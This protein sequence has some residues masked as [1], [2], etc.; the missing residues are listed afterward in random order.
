MAIKGDHS[1]TAGVELGSKWAFNLL[2]EDSML[3]GALLTEGTAFDEL[4]GWLE[5]VGSR[6]G[7]TPAALVLD[8]WAIGR[9]KYADSCSGWRRG[10]PRIST[11][12]S[13]RGI[14]VASQP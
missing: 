7:M 6:P 14:N 12:P 11:A 4:A 9:E 1:A 5:D 10:C 8:N 3:L 13:F 2:N